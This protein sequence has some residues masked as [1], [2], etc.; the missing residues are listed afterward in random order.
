MKVFKNKDEVK[1]DNDKAEKR[2]EK[3]VA[4]ADKLTMNYILGKMEEYHATRKYWTITIAGIV[5]MSAVCIITDIFMPMHGAGWNILRAFIAFGMGIFDFML[6][7]TLAIYQGIANEKHYDDN[8]PIDE[9]VDPYQPFRLRFSVRQRRRQSYPFIAI[10]VVIAI[11]SAYSHLYT[12]LGGVVVAGVIAIIAYIRPTDD[13][14]VLIM[15]DMPDTRD[16]LD[17]AEEYEKEETKRKAQEKAK[18]LRKARKDA[19]KER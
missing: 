2:R 16:I 6:G 18:A 15:N 11:A 3:A 5:V 12:L 7:Y 14:Y 10:I 1:A 13:E 17:I 19:D 4:F 9:V 8:V